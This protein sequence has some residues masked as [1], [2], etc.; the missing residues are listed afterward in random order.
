MTHVFISYKR[1]DELR[2]GRIARALEVAGLEVWWDRGLPGGESWHSNI[3]AKLEGAGCV[4]VVW[5]YGSAS[6]DGGFVRE[7]A[8]RGIARNILVPV[9]IDPLQNL[10]LGFGEIQA[11]DLARW[12]GDQHD[13][14][15]ADL[16]ATIRA[17]LEHAPLPTPRGPTRRVARRLMWGSLSGAGV[18][19]AALLACNT[20]GVASR[21][22]SVPGPQP[23]L[24]DSCGALGL[25]GRPGRTERIAWESRAPGSCAAL[26]EHIA[27]FPDGAYR[28][29]AADL[30]TGRKVSVRETW[31]ATTKTLTLFEPSSVSPSKDEAAARA[32]ALSRG[33]LSSDR[34]CR[35]FGAGSLYRYVSSAPVPENWSCTKDVTGTVCGFDGHAECELNQRQQTEHE[36]CG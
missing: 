12:R 15:F 33:Q 3:E 2:V 8:R 32:A 31:L 13:P 29:Q 17:K 16:V 18:T 35:A 5:S 1:E 19:T 4:V 28:A 36:S 22:C 7:E 27:R 30:L 23:E 20:F 25:G 11:I 24:S 34:L 21:L 26:R 14:F 9:L 10:P 6:Q